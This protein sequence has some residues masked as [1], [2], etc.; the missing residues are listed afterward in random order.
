MPGVKIVMLP[1]IARYTTTDK[2]ARIADET[3]LSI[4]QPPETLAMRGGSTTD[5]LAHWR[6]MNNWWGFALS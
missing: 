1:A 3:W 4:R 2:D 6:K 5:S